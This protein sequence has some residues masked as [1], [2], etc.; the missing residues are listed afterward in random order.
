ML[1]TATDIQRIFS[2]IHFTIAKLIAETLGK[3]YLTQ[4]DITLLK[5]KGVDLVKLI[6]KFPSHYQ[7]FLFG[8]L[9]AAIG[10]KSTASLSYSDF[11][12]FLNNMGALAPTT[13]EMAFYKVAADKTYTHIK[14]LGERIRNDVQ[15]SVASEELNFLA[16]QEAAKARKT[17]HDE[18]LNGTFERKAVKKIAANIAHQMVDWGRDWGRIVETECQDVYNLGRAQFMLTQNSDPLVYF[19]VYP[20]ACRHCIRLYLTGGIGSKPRIFRLSELLSNGT[21]YGVKT[22]DW[23]AT[24]HPVHPF[25]RCDLRYLPEGYEWNDETHQ[26]EP[27]PSYK[28]KVERKGKVKITIGNKEY[29]V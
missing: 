11:E 19:D 1:F 4:E 9:A 23:K 29:I 7:A 22:K 26:F 20:G 15:A 28:D 2:N 13:V 10:P 18:I 6:P 3:D 14:G 16:A 17:I 21:N 5:K 27:K 12:K 25:C 8:K 24:I